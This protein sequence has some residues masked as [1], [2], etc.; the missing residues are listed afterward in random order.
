MLVK[1]WRVGGGKGSGK[2]GGIVWVFVGGGLRGKN[3]EEIKLGKLN[4]V[5]IS[6]KNGREKWIGID[7]EIVG[8]GD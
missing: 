1:S 2:E 7:K 4:D 6:W 3:C 5:R 8:W